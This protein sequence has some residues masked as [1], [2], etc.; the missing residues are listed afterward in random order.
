[1]YIVKRESTWMVLKNSALFF[2]K[3]YAI[4]KLDLGIL[5]GNV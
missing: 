2:A 3:H 4:G 1:M 5:L